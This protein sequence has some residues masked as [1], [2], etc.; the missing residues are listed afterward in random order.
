L[1]I[2]VCNFARTVSG[3]L[4][5]YLSLD[6]RN[7]SIMH[8]FKCWGKYTFHIRE[9]A[10]QDDKAQTLGD[11]CL[12]LCS[13]PRRFLNL[14]SLD[15]SGG[16]R[17]DQAACVV[18]HKQLCLQYCSK[19]CLNDFLIFYLSIYNFICRS[20]QRTARRTKHRRCTARTA[21][22]AALFPTCF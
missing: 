16:L 14:N 3:D 17:N 22:S 2:G 6:V 10:L 4:F 8:C 19:P 18:Q 20:E 9:G 5:I 12:Q 11:P 7:K 13:Q 21:M 1:A 15:Q